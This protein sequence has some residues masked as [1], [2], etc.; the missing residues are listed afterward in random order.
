MFAVHFNWPSLP[1]AIHP[2]ASS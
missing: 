1:S 2:M